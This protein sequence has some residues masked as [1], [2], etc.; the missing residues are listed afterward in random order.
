VVVI[1]TGELVAVGVV[2][3]LALLVITTV[4]WSLLFR[5]DDVNVLPVAPVTGVPFTDHWYV[6]VVP[7]LDGVAVNVIDVP[8]QMTV[9]LAATVTDGVIPV[10]TVIAIGALVAE[11]AVK[12]FA[13]L[14]IVTVT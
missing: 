1:T 3:Q 6:G 12:Q 10:V 5:V 13:L 11:V 7:P 4:T 2:R 8:A 9:W 14:A